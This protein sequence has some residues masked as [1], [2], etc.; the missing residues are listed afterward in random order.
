MFALLILVVFPFSPSDDAEPPASRAE[1]FGT[2]GTVSYGN[3][4]VPDQFRATRSS[5]SSQTRFSPN[6]RPG[7]GSGPG[8][9][10]GMGPGP[11]SG[12]SPGQG[13]GLSI[14]GIGAGGGDVTGYGQGIGGGGPDFFGLGGSARGVQKVVYV[15]DRSGSMYD[16]FSFVRHELKRSVSALR[17]SQK[18]HVIFFNV[19]APLENPPRRLVPAV[20]A[21]REQLFTF[22]D[23]IVPGGGTDPI[24]AMRRAF[25]VQPDLIYLLTDGEFKPTLMERLEEWNRDRRVRIFTIAFLGAGGGP[26]LERIAREHG[27]EYRYVSEDDLP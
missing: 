14:I 10:P 3:S 4:P 23:E 2:A 25:E 27:G 24:P 11:R 12:L 6:L 15:V 7:A 17:R 13:E 5:G 19:G 9:G 18:F 1:F 16:T 21:H 8:L 22:L 26:M 20:T